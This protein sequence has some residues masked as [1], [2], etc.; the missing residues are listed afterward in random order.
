MA[1]ITSNLRSN[2]HDTL[3]A[4]DFIIVSHRNFLE[5]IN[6]LKLLRENKGL[7]V[8]VVDVDDI[9]DEFSYGNKS[10]QAIKDFLLYSHTKW[11]SGPRFALF[12]GD[13]SFDHKN[14]LGA[15]DFDFVPSRF[16]DT[17][18]METVSDDW[19]ADFDGDG[20]AEI[21]LGRL[22]VRTADETSRIIDKIVSYGI[23]PAARNI[24]L[25]SDLNDGIDFQSGLAGIRNL[26]PAGFNLAEIDRGAIE[27]SDA[28]RELIER[29]NRGLA[30]LTYFGHGNVDQWRGGLLTSSDATSLANGINRPVVFAITCLNGYFQDPVLDSL[31]ESFI[32]A[33]R[34]GAI[35]VWASSGLCEAW[36]Q[37][38]LNEE[39][40]RALFSPS[41]TGIAVSLGEAALKAKSSISDVEV[42][43]TYILFGDPTLS[44]QL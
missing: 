40:Y 11:Q 25:V 17:F 15:G 10:T 8:M 18:W 7:K 41:S 35:A 34:G 9:Y 42:R 36:P 24:L 26:I 14:Y 21:A 38:R 19:F 31:A 44:L 22:P 1:A 29:I 43:L 39:M 6:P 23:V 28:R 20:I 32:K 16:I 33:E 3:N 2:L 13:S 37:S 27:T 5:R 12:V 4:A 30:L